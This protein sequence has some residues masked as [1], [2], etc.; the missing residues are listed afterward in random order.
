MPFD[1]QGKFF[2]IALKSASVPLFR[3]FHKYAHIYRQLIISPLNWLRISLPRVQ[4]P[5]NIPLFCFC[6]S[7]FDYFSIPLE[8]LPCES[9]SRIKACNQAYTSLY[10][11]LWYQPLVEW[12]SLTPSC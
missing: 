3:H 10:E 2:T 12:V 8:I 5:F 11:H 7:P 9:S 6:S 1:Q 4:Q